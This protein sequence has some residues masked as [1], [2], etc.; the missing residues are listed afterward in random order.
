MHVSPA[1]TVLMNYVSKS[2]FLSLSGIHFQGTHLEPELTNLMKQFLMLRCLRGISE[3]QPIGE[4]HSTNE[5]Y[6]AET[7]STVPLT[8]V[9]NSLQ[10]AINSVILRSG[11]F[12]IEYILQE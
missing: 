1:G 9:Q 5:N 12:K 2:I 10:I 4:V 6:T 7:Q 3:H 11:H 8:A